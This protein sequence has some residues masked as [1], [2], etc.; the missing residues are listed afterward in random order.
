MLRLARTS[1]TEEKQEVRASL[2]MMSMKPVSQKETRKKKPFG[3]GICSY[4]HG[5]GKM[6]CG[7][8][9]FYIMSCVVRSCTARP[10]YL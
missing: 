8:S 9:R 3:I 5:G 2:S 4:A 7:G 6:P 1:C 10:P